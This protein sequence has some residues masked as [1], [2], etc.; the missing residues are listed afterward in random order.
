MHNPR[1]SNHECRQPEVPLSS[2]THARRK[3]VYNGDKSLA[4]ARKESQQAQQAQVTEAQ[5]AQQQTSE[6]H[7]IA[8]S[9]G[10]APTPQPELEQIP[11]SPMNFE[12]DNP[13]TSNPTD[14][15]I[16]LDICAYIHEEM[17]P[18]GQH[19]A[20][21]CF[22]NADQRP[23]IT[24]E[25]LAELDMP[26]IINNPKLRHDVNFDRELHFRPNLDGS[27]GRQKMLQADQYWRALEAE[28]VM[29]QFVATRRAT[30]ADNEDYWN[31]CMK[32]C[33]VRLPKIFHAIRDILKTLVPDYD[34]KAV[35]ERLEVDHIMQQIQNGVCDLV[36]LGN[37]LAKVLKNHCAPM[38]DMLVD[39]M[40]KEIRRGATEG[41]HE[42]LVSGL[43]QLMNILEAMKLDVANHQIRHMRPLL[44]D[45]TINF[46]RRYNAHR[47]AIGKIN[48]PESRDWLQEC[49][50][51]QD[52][53]LDALTFGLIRDM[54]N[55]DLANMCPQTFYLDTDRLRALRVELHSRVYHYVCRDVLKEITP[56]GMS[57]VDFAKACDM[58]QNS[59][60]A[61]VGVQ[62]RF[63]DRF[64]NIAVEIVRVS[65]VARGQTPPFD[66]ELLNVV[67]QKLAEY[68]QPDSESFTRHAAVL[69]RNLVPKVQARVA[70]HVRMSALDLQ[71][72]LVPQVTSTNRN[73]M[74]FGAVMEPAPSAPVTPADADEDIIRRFTHI[75]AL[76]WQ[77]WSELV[78]LANDPLKSDDDTASESGSESTMVT[79]AQGSP[80]VPV[81]TAVYAPGRKWLPVSVTVT[82][83]PSHM[84]TPESSSAPSQQSKDGEAEQTGDD[85]PEGSQQRRQPA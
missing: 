78:Y 71:D 54:L 42:K 52:S 79:S 73:S 69:T 66:V 36:D 35:L 45:D 37:W 15:E 77:V 57:A 43:R 18:G 83:V 62:G 85:T 30:S 63:A 59:I 32:G 4:T 8:Y 26:R 24:P 10:Q 44:I 40:Q 72:M 31:R 48:M 11:P 80:T 75:I 39:S 14:D 84:S 55:N 56:P 81:A 29:L 23:P 38:R 49:L 17:D 21:W 47:I 68:L 1:E 46:Q 3:S 76:H 70:E 67:E 19:H 7:G 2:P 82:D 28:L 12:L 27:K 13:D 61:I 9:P 64:D 50:P 58:L 34:Q 53:H 65:L 22:E 16:F 33:M 74:G 25:S 5:D 20:S 6:T 60:A 51:E 41:K